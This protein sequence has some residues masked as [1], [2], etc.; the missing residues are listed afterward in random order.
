[1][2]AVPH[3]SVLQRVR[4]LFVLAV[5]IPL[6]LGAWLSLKQVESSL[7]EQSFNRSYDAA[8]FHGTLILENLI[9]AQYSLEASGVDKQ[10]AVAG[11][12]A[13]HA[14]VTDVM[15]LDER[16]ATSRRLGELPRTSY[17][18]E[19]SATVLEASRVALAVAPRTGEIFMAGLLADSQSK[20]HAYVARLSGARVFGREDDQ[21]VNAELCVLER[22]TLVYCTSDLESEATQLRAAFKAR[23]SRGRFTWASTSGNHYM[24]S[25]RELF[26]PS[27]FDSASW[28]IIV[29][30][31]DSVVFAPISLFR[32][33]F[34]AATALMIFVLLFLVVNQ[35]R[36][37]LGPISKLQRHAERVGQGDFQTRLELHTSNEFEQ[38]ADS[39]NGMAQRLGD[40]FQFLKA[41]SDIDSALLSST[42]LSR[43]CEAILNSIA[44]LLPVQSAAILAIDPKQQSESTL[45]VY[46]ASRSHGIEVIEAPPVDSEFTSEWPDSAYKF[47]GEAVP[48][49]K[50][51]SQY[52]P[53]SGQFLVHALRF[54]DSVIGALCLR[55]QEQ[56]TLTSE[57]EERITSFK[58]RLT[59]ALSTLERQRKLYFQAHFDQLTN[60]PNRML[61]LDR[62]SQYFSQARRQGNKVAVIYADLDKFKLVNDTL[63]HERGDE[64]LQEAASRLSALV[65]GSDTV[66]RLAGDEFAL[67]LPAIEHEEDVTKVINSVVRAFERPF[68][69]L[70][71]EFHLNVSM[72]IAFFPQDGDSASDVLKRADI[73]M[74]RAKS[75]Q[76]RSFVFYEE[77]MNEDLQERTTLAQE[78]KQ[79]LKNGALSLV[80]QPKVDAV[81]HRIQSAEALIRWNHPTRGWVSPAKFIPIAEDAGLIPEIGEYALNAACEQFAQWREQN[82]AIKQVAVNVSPRQIQYTD[83]VA[84]VEATLLKTGIPAH[85]LELEVTED[86]L[87]E[88]YEKTERVLADL[89]SLGVGLALD[90]FG[91][92]YSSLGHIHEL[93]FDTLKIDK[94]FVDNIGESKNSDAIVRS[95]VALGKTLNKKLVAEGVENFHQ[96]QFLTDVGCQLIQGYYFSK[97]LSGEDLTALLLMNTELPVENV[98]HGSHSAILGVSIELGQSTC[99]SH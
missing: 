77:R 57:Y 17:P 18:G 76:A 74:Y 58:D 41:M 2:S 14:F 3:Q 44:E 49:M 8:R 24:A 15:Y 47:D 91:T 32:W 39:F 86:L 84:L 30:E 28:D 26:L 36:R 98:H 46:A 66:A 72:G 95:I 87:I 43:L 64:L 38:L 5:L 69:L 79:A 51:L 68:T 81:S 12:Q 33:M 42:D 55:L 50:P 80:Y 35:T 93:S 62:M 59:V 11:V 70:A 82:L 85:C 67:A 78:L 90:D 94:C 21:L 52:L 13:E 45:H 20:D 34:P 99:Q 73:A 22:E 88:D 23:D 19:L 27:H 71:Q 48:G 83:I 75:D 65:R 1:M 53:G 63:G 29:V 16:G 10:L 31:R 96:L 9:G 37:H 60:L 40:Q 61:F 4:I 7:V 56:A 97:P 6:G 54:D 89:G 92:G 25:S